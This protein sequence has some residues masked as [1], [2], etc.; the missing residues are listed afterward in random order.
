MND[1]DKD[2][3]ESFEEKKRRLKAY[4]REALKIIEDHKSLSDDVYLDSLMLDS[5][6]RWIL[7]E[8]RR[9]I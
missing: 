2:F 9:I 1:E 4:F 5:K 6:I 7:E 8:V 3:V